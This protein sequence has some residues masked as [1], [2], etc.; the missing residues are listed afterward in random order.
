MEEALVRNFA[1]WEKSMIQL[2]PSHSLEDIY[3]KGIIY[4][5]KLYDTDYSH[6]SQDLLSLE[7]LTGREFCVMEETPIICHAATAAPET[8]SLLEEAGVNVPSIRYIYKNDDEYKR[9]LD[10][11]KMQ[12]KKLIFQYP[13]PSEDISKDIYWIEPAL[14][15]YLCDKRNIP[16]LVPEGHFPKRRL[17]SFE[18]ILKEKPALPFVLKTGDGRATSGGFGVLLVNNEKQLYEIDD[19]FGDLSQLIVEESIDYDQNISV[20]YVADQYGK[21]N[22][23][24]MSE[25]LVSKAGNF[26]GS[27]ISTDIDDKF[28]EI[29][30]VGN[31]VME[32][33]VEKGYVGFAGFDV[34][35]KGDQFYFIDL[36]V[37]FNASTCGLLLMKDIRNKLGKKVVRLCNFE[38]LN[39]FKS[40]ILVMKKYVSNQQIIP[41]SLLHANQ[42]SEGK[43]KAIGL[44]AAHSVDEVESILSEMSNE[45]LL[46]KE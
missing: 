37:R 32:N 10:N 46:V 12:N 15:A 30:A 18:Q 4:N 21:V 42:F 41:L 24:G 35:I 6:F 29:V 17:M 13:H 28:A 7:V 43:Q 5:P 2:R 45:G 3:G 16:E 19:T 14:H 34:L 44:V 38:W 39:D 33:I 9:L 31:K 8:L 36:N 27:W 20:H 1:V 22:F 25:Q 11:L 23:L 26:R 40:L